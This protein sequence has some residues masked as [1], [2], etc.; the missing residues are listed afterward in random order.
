MADEQ[1]SK[2]VLMT[3]SVYAHICNFHLP[4]LREFQHLGWE[5][6]V[7]CADIPDEA[8]YINRVFRLPFKKKILSTANFQAA[9][10]LRKLIQTEQYDLIVTHTSLAAFFTRIAS[11]GLKTRPKLVNVMHGYLFD[12]RTHFPKRWLLLG[13]E[14][15]TAPETDLLLLMNEW[16]FRTA[17]K[18]H[19]GR[20]IEK[21]PGM[22]VDF[23]R[24]NTA[25]DEEGRKLRKQLDI[26]ED[27]FILIYPAE[28]SKRKSQHVLIEAMQLLPEN[29]WLILCGEGDQLPFYQALAERLGVQQRVRFPGQIKDIAT[30]YRMADAL[31]AS[32]RSE[33]L[34]FNI[35]E[36]MH[37][38]LPVIASAVKGHT[39][40]IED[41]VNGA[42]YPYGNI[43]EC[44]ACVK[45]IMSVRLFSMRQKGTPLA[46][47]EP[48][49]LSAVL[50]Q[51]MAAYLSVAE[52]IDTSKK[53]RLTQ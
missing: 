51:V 9:L 3:A 39:D 32:S 52:D 44:A 47:V 49:R 21:I 33:G 8:P 6:H 27:A 31:V 15:L 16:D 2:K 26:P 36:A 38:G 48:Y 42:L 19:L 30:W 17:K 35:M 28:L 4:Y 41:G 45:R 20:R 29:V 34:P 5:T 40:L 24:L 11:K 25:T 37:V 23:R 53:E 18:Y 10:M 46:G 14:R 1:L 7:G 50:P 13:A 22:G 12:E 43:K